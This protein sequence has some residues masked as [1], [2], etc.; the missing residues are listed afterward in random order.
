MFDL[1]FKSGLFC[2]LGSLGLLL[3]ACEAQEETVADYANCRY[4]KP[5]AIF[6][7]ELPQISDHQFHDKG[8]GSE[9]SFILSG[10]V[11]VSI[12][13]YG[14]DQ[15]TQEFAFELGGA[16]PCDTPAA[17][18]KQ[19]AQLFLALSRLGPEYHVFRVWSHAIRDIS[20]QVRFGASLQLGEGFWIKV[21]KKEGSG[22]TTLLLT[23]SE[24]A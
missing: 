23:L 12:L 17:C 4:E 10:G 2:L 24:N 15:R 22:R 11:A 13:Q 21:D 6:Y 3:G 9:E 14:C 8:A 20:D 19:A 7:P 1:N 16:S 18:T 5:E